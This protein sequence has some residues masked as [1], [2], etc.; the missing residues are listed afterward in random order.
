MTTPSI[1]TGDGCFEL[2]YD[3][4]NTENFGISRL[5]GAF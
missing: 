1:E 3:F 2:H 4:S 5:I